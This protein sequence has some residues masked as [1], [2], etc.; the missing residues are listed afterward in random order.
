MKPDPKTGWCHPAL[1]AAHG[2][3]ER[4]MNEAPAQSDELAILK[5][6][7]KAIEAADV[8]LEAAQ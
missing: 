6:V 5:E 7:A 3:L 4:A 1:M 8:E 2:L